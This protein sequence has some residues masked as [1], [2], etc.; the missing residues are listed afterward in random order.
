MD[1]AVKL[2]H[3][4]DALFGQGVSKHLPKN[5]EISFSKRTGRIREVYHNQKLL[6]TLRIDGGLAIT[7]FFAQILMKSKKF[8]ENCLEVD[9]ESKPFVEDGR[10][11]F[12]GHIVWCGK[13]IRIQSE[14]PILYKNRVIAVGKAILSSKMMSGQTRGVAVKVRDSLKSQPKG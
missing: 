5:I 13:S 3:N 9:Q 11:V 6:C 1:P 8:K 10:S 12:C 7:P 2:S 14:V 4:I